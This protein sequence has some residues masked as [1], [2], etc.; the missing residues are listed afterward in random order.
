MVSKIWGEGGDNKTRKL[1]LVELCL[2]GPEVASRSLMLDAY[3]CLSIISTACGAHQG[4]C[5]T[6][7]IIAI[8]FS[9]FL[10][11][12]PSFQPAAG[13]GPVSNKLV[14]VGVG[15]TGAFPD[16]FVSLFPGAFQ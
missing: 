10:H 16:E 8:P 3:I 12:L 11:P 5:L 4:P 14:A 13:V 6:F 1:A 2:S 7:L 9:R 15:P